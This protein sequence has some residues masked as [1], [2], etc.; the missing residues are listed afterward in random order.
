MSQ[1]FPGTPGPAPRSLST[2]MMSKEAVVRVHEVLPE[3]STSSSEG[4]DVASH[5]KPL[6]RALSESP[7]APS[8]GSGSK[9][10][11]P[12]GTPERGEGGERLFETFSLRA[13]RKS[14]R[15]GAMGDTSNP[16]G[17]EDAPEGGV[18]N[19]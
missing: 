18:F 9:L 10:G 16:G 12:G 7:D 6:P 5:T 17:I 1:N 15:L 3:M 14:V 11:G 8:G 19:L 13:D 2:S 4:G